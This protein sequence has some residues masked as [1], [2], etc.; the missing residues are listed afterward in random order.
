VCVDK[1][2]S[3]FSKV[4]NFSFSS[5]CQK[6]KILEMKI[7][8]IKL[9]FIKKSFVFE[10]YFSFLLFLFSFFFFYENKKVNTKYF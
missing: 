6:R 5:F 10:N 3:G 8:F 9:F 2:I 4:T 1:N 7:F